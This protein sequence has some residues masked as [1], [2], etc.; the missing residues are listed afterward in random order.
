MHLVYYDKLIVYW[1]THLVYWDTRTYPIITLLP[2]QLCILQGGS[3]RSKV[4]LH[5]FHSCCRDNRRRQRGGQRG[6]ETEGETEGG[7]RGDRGGGTRKGDRGGDRGGDK[8]RRE[9][10]KE[11]IL[12]CI[13]LVTGESGTD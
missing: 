5:L 9:W 6:K 2:P 3:G 12:F 10:G 1:N 7:P 11:R 4:P 8:R 13:G